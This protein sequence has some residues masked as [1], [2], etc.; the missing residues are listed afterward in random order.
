MQILINNKV[1]DIRLDENYTFKSNDS[2]E[3]FSD[4]QGGVWFE[5]QFYNNILKPTHDDDASREDVVLVNNCFLVSVKL[6]FKQLGYLD[7]D[8]PIK[9]RSYQSIEKIK[10]DLI[11]LEQR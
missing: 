1:T 3:F 8:V 6:L 5:K 11:R 4:D 10:F 2:I 9:Q 7:K